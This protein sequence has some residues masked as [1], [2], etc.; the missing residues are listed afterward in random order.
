MKIT[1]EEFER[2]LEVQES[3]NFNMYIEANSA[4]EAAHLSVKQWFFILDNYDKIEK[5]YCTLPAFWY[6]NKFR[7]AKQGGKND[8]K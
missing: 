1:D 8:S 6:N 4:S 7:R 3:G 2:F 5:E